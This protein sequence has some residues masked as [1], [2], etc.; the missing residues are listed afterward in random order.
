MSLPYSI[1]KSLSDGHFH[2]GEALASQTG[3][4]RA[5]VWKAIQTLQ[6]H[7]ALDIH[8]VHGRGYR[9]PQSLELLDNASILQFLPGY[10]RPAG[11]ETFLSIDST[12]QYLMQAHSNDL[13]SP[14]V[15]LAEQQT[16]GRGRRGRPWQSPFAGNIYLSML[17][18]FNQVNANFAGL[19]LV[20]G[21]VMCRVLVH[22]GI[23]QLGL[24]WPNDVLCQQRK[25]CGI[26]I[27][28]RGETNGPYDAV[29]GIGLNVNMPDEAG[30]QIDQP[31]I[32]LSDVADTI[33]SRNK[34]AAMMIEALS[35]ALPQ[36]EAD[37]LRPF[38]AEWRRLDAY[39]DREVQLQLGEK[40]VTGIERGIDD[41]GALLVEHGGKQQRYYS[42][43]ISLRAR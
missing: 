13:E 2:S 23:E 16:A 25:L 14:R 35:E 22:I 26:L 3:V 4:T 12:N 33:P 38:L 7:F 39:R 30:R 34:L 27:E 24:K 8:S 32:A 5:A 21:V 11:L 37:G 29:I 18:R 43:E 28:M 10:R 36:F 17:W 42:G 1:L 20:V 40:I 31:W 9:L 41:Q 19:S 6:K 15:V